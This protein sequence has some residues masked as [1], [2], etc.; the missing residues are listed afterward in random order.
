MKHPMDSTFD[1]RS[2]PQLFFTDQ[3]LFYIRKL[4]YIRAD[5]GPVWT[6]EEWQTHHDIVMKVKHWDMDRTEE[7]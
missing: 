5:S 2:R 7:N 1:R 3:E 6:T 4:C